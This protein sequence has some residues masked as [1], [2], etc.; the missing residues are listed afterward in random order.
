MASALSLA[1]GRIQSKLSVD[2]AGGIFLVSQEDM[3]ASVQ[4]IVD[5][6]VVQHQIE[7]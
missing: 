6:E 1:D 7:W 3:Q 2:L 5:G 4:T